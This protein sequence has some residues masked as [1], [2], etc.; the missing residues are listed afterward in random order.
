MSEPN[1]GRKAAADVL[2]RVAE[3]GS[4]A[5]PSLSAALGQGIDPRDRALATEIVYGTLRSLPEVDAAVAAHLRS[6]FENLD[7]Y[8]RAAFRTGAYQL[9]H[10][11]APVHA[12][13]SDTVSI[14]RNERGP[15]LGGLVN[16]VLRKVAAKRPDD[17]SPPTTMA[18]PPWLEEALAADL[19]EERA[20]AF[21][22][23]RP[24]PPPIGLRVRSGDRAR[25]IAEIREE[26]PR[27]EVKEGAL[28]P[29]SILVRR[30][31]DP[32]TLGAY[33]RGAV[34]IQEQ[35]AQ[36]VGLLMG[37][38]S[39]ERV[40]DACAGRGGKT[41]QLVE[42]VG[43][44]G[45]VTAIDLHEAKLERI[46]TELS[47]LGIAA[48]VETH[49]IDLAVGTGGLDAGF[50][51]VLVDAPCT[52]IGTL[53][54]RPEILIRLDQS[55]PGRM[56]K[57]QASILAHACQLAAPGGTIVYAVCS[58]TR[59]EGIGVVERVLEAHPEL[60]ERAPN[61]DWPSLGVAPDPDG[62]VRIGPWSG[63][64]DAYQI[65]R[66]VRRSST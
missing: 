22:Q 45:A 42:A 18:L 33:R 16:A 12:I 10:L 17:A 56:A 53:H 63:D 28:T 11:S 8:V 37:A 38:A 44:S 66:L 20:T 23:A 7:G 49:T 60:V 46:S 31:G 36:V 47:R 35:G 55:E 43:S 62:V 32:H 65:A 24:L 61:G 6:P 27:A 15:K 2:H 29:A 25:V 48:E 41:L 51:R 26:R 13:V 3:S 58:P 50:D 19:G 1:P 5:A 52:G 9:L 59:E 21:T 4:W 14:V 64:C 54:R 57:L 40:V 30:G 39:G 34:T